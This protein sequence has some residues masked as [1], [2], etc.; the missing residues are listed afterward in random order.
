MIFLTVLSVNFV[1]D[2]LR[3]QDAS[4]VVIAYDTPVNEQDEPDLAPITATVD[5]LAACLEKGAT[6][7]VSS[8]V[9]VGTCEALAVR[10]GP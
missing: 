8:Q 5:A 9:P 7:I 10:C 3:V 2:G 1:G 6:I 4:Y